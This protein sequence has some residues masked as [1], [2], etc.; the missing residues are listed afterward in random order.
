MLNS[1]ETE[2]HRPCKYQFSVGRYHRKLGGW[3]D[4]GVTVNEEWRKSSMG[5]KRSGDDGRYTGN[6]GNRRCREL[7][8]K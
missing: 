7:N 6:L 5:N 1:A 4:F 8:V 2:Y 3:L